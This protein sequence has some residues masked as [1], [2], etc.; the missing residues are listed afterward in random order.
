MTLLMIQLSF[1]FLLLL[2]ASWVHLVFS[3]IITVRAGP[4]RGL[5]GRLIIW[6]PLKSIFFKLLWPT[7]GLG[8]MLSVFDEIA[9]NSRRNTFACGNLS[10][11]V[12]YLRLFYWSLRAP[13]RVAEVPVLIPALITI[14]GKLIRVLVSLNKFGSSTSYEGAEVE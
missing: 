11:L 7:T 13:H 12:P 2:S 9:N 1:S 4:R 10:L 14:V 3:H 5:P 8:K 6:S